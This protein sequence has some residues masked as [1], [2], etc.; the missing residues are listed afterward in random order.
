MDEPEGGGG[1]GAVI[2]AATLPNPMA[3]VSRG[4]ALRGGTAERG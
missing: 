4:V 3:R 1:G 2:A